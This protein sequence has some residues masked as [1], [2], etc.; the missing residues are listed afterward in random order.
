M[1]NVGGKKNKGDDWGSGLLERVGMG[2]AEVFEGASKGWH[3]G[4]G[5][6]L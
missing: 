5:R 2:G 4:G 1:K 3:E 6:F